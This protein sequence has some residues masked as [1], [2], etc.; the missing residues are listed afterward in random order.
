[1]VRQVAFEESKVS[2]ELP[3]GFKVENETKNKGGVYLFTA[4]NNF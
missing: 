1:M 3:C 2:W 4:D